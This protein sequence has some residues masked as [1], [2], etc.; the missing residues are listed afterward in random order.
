M[1]YVSIESLVYPRVSSALGIPRKPP[2][3]CGLRSMLSLLRITEPLTQSQRL[4]APIHQKKFSVHVVFA[5]FYAPNRC[6]SGFVLAQAASS[7][8][9]SKK[10]S[11]QA[12]GRSGDST[13]ERHQRAASSRSQPLN[14]SQVT[15]KSITS[16]VNYSSVH[17][18]T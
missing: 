1:R 18:F 6:L 8:G 2:K 15:I 10:A 4:R 14:L 11:T 12:S 13:T 9:K 17:G 7:S 5:M 3:R 16:E